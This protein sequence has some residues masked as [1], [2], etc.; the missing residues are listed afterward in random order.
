M[1][2]VCPQCKTEYEFDER[3]VTTAGVSVQCTNCSFTFKVRRREVV[4]IDA[5][6]RRPSAESEVADA[7]PWMIECASGERL[8]FRELAT[9]LEEGG[10]HTY[11]AGKWHLGMSP[12]KLPNSRGFE[13]SVAMADSGA[14]HWEQKPYLPL[15]K[16]ANWFAD[17]ERFTLGPLQRRYTSFTGGLK[18]TPGVL[19]ADLARIR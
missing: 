2:I 7:Q 18:A 13:R 16:E 5:D 12:E 11:M 9:L 19:K 3:H 15:Y 6:E 10:Y 1:D 17:G 8:R 14:D 4:E